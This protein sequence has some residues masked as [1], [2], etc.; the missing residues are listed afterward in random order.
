MLVKKA[1]I[2]DNLATKI[3]THVRSYGAANEKGELFDRIFNRGDTI[4]EITASKNVVGQGVSQMMYPNGMAPDGF[5]TYS[6]GIGVSTKSMDVDKVQNAIAENQISLYWRKNVERALKYDTV[7]CRSEVNESLIQLCNE[8]IYKDDIDEICS[9]SIDHDAE[10]GDAVQLKLG[11]IFRRDVLRKIMQFDKNGWDYMKYLLTRGRIFLEVL[12]DQ[13]SG[14][15]VGVNMLPEENVI[16]VVQDNLIIG[17]RQMLTGAISMQNGGKNYID[18]SPNQILY[19]SLGMTGPGGINDPRSILEPAMKPYNQ[20][21]TIED[22][23]VMYR[24]LWGSEKL[25]MKV[26]TSGMTKATAEKFM[27]DQAKVFSRKL[28]YNSMTGE[29]TNFG[30]VVGLTEHYIIGVG[31][32]RTGS[33]IERMNGGEQLGNIDDLKF[34][35][36]NLVNALM[37]PPGRITALAGDSQNYSQGKIGEVTQA[38]VSFARLVQ[39]YQTPFENILV[40]L[41]VMVL[42]TDNSLS[43]DIKFQDLYRVRFRKSNG[44]QNFI[45]SEVW[46]TKLQVFD[47]MMKHV[48]SKEN[49]SGALSKQAALRWGL[50]L[51]D[52]QYNLNKKWCKEEEKEASGE[53]TS[54][55]DEA[56]DAGGAGGSI[57]GM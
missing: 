5:S 45:D 29:I 44:F 2:P 41:F 19:A 46:T 4:R 26:D 57:P 34:F 49:P 18:F 38:E 30:K 15:I 24:V 48:S 27:K 53:D 6:P 7:A 16:I 36:R 47:A 17:Y 32:G 10:I 54:G 21:N 56:P 25:V 3:L 8:A 1:K 55:G 50:R 33:S 23:V 28:D 31:Q 39:R 11:R 35:K 20:L 52:E 42:N 43:E 40:R 13:G 22:S 9:L 51:D 37:V 14:R 12:Y